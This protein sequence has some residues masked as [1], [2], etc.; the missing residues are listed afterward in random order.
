MPSFGFFRGARPIYRVEV[1][2]VPAFPADPMSLVPRS[3]GLVGLGGELTVEGVLEAYKKGIFPWTGAPPIPWYS[4]DPRMILEPRA[5]V[6]S[7]S[8]RQVIQRG[9]LRVEANRD[10][11]GM[12]CATTPRPG[13][14]GTW[15][16]P[17]MVQV[18]G[19]L[20]RLG[21][22]HSVEVYLGDGP[23]ARRV[24]GLYG[25]S[26]GRAFFG[27]SM[28]SHVPNA[29]KVALVWLCR[30]LEAEGFAFIDCQQE[31]PHLASMGACPIPRAD[32]VRWVMEVTQED[33]L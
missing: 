17:N 30:K 5:V 3:D 33:G 20:H 22:A 8:L 25:L 14:G 4:P 31:T 23:E 32:Y 13:Q 29:S 21:Y 27:E 26:I 10:F 6:V 15:I 28:C 24:G 12:M 11:V 2:K 18:W 7:R 16:T 9:E 1:G 19:E